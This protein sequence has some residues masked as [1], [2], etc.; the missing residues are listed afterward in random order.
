MEERE[1]D[2]E[3]GKKIEREREKH[4]HIGEREMDG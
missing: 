1:I 2:E 4:G 3:A